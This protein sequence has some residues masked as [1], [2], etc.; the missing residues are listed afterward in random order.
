MILLL[1]V[2]AGI[3][4]GLARASRGQRQLQPLGLQHGWLV[5]VAFI[6][7][8]IAFQLPFTSANI[9]DDVARV[10]LVS[11]QAVLIAFAWLNRKAPGF[12]ALGLGL[13]LN[14]T[15]IVLNGGLMPISP[16]IIAHFGVDASSGLYQVGERLGNEKDILLPISETRL[17]WLSDRFVPPTW[18]PYRVA[19][20]I[21]DIFIGVGSFLL[22]WSMGGPQEHQQE[23]Q[24]EPQFF[25]Q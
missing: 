11:S 24:N 14:F 22:F 23:V 5:I 17:W 19:F 8:L 25:P 18:I 21:G 12:W 13:L 4:A 3:I 15:V 2:V 10:A 1:A 16:E 7:Q 20:S 9:P 6:P